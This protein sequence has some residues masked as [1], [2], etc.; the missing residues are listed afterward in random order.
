MRIRRARAAGAALVAMVAVGAAFAA[1]GSAGAAPGAGDARQ[2]DGR[3]VRVEVPGP[4]P[5]ASADGRKRKDTPAGSGYVRVPASGGPADATDTAEPSGSAAD[6]TV[7]KVIDNGATADKLDVVFVGDGY[8]E[9]EL[10]QFKTDV[11]TKWNDVLG[12]EPYTTY[13]KLFNVWAVDAVS[14]DSGVSGDPA[15]GTVK[16][17]ALGSNFWCGDIE[18]LLCVDTNKLDR[19]VAKAPEADLVIVLANSTKYGGAGYTGGN[20]QLGYEGIATASA[21]NSDSGQIA[22]HETGHSLGKLDDEYTYAEYGRYT[23]AE[24]GSLNSSIYTADQLAARQTKWYRWLGQQSPDGGTVGAYE[25]SSYYP[26]GIYRPTENSIMRTLGRKFNLPGA[27]AM[28]NGFHRHA[29]TV[30]A[31]AGVSTRSALGPGAR[32]SV[33]VPTPIGDRGTD[34]RWY[35]D[36]TEVAGL[37]GKTDVRI[38]EGLV[39]DDGAEHTLTARAVDRTDAVR[40]PAV[41][42]ALTDSVEWRVHG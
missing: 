30:T 19:Y 27:E 9:G 26:Q 14:V 34:L 5:A 12:V 8:R 28:V 21:G 22:I 33:E 3:T 32:A 42:R 41:R 40:D 18:R 7:T 24:L 11:K 20:A 36:G 37:R 25:G 2:G 35:L 29:K 38:T 15:K 17:T 31:G 1:P 16:N 4:E 23:G 6:G 39:P 13:Q 10:A